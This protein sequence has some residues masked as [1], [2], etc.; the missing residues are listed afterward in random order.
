MCLRHKDAHN[1]HLHFVANRV[2][3]D[4]LVWHGQHDLH[5]AGIESLFNIANKTNHIVIILLDMD[6]VA[7]KI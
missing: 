6:D 3:L 4:G 2:G 7:F 5:T 1:N